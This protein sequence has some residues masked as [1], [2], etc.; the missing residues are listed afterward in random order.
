MR[1]DPHVLSAR[2]DREWRSLSRRPDHIARARAW[3]VTTTPFA[4]LDGLLAL[5]GYRLDH[6][7]ER[8]AVLVALVRRGGHDDLAARIVLQRVMPGLLAVIRRRGWS[9]DGS[10]EELVGAAWL[11]I[12]G[13]RAE[14]APEQIAANIV[15]DAAYRAFTAPRR[16]RSA[17]EVSVDPKTL[18][19]T[20]AVHRV[21]A[22]EELAVLMSDAIAAGLPRHDLE[23]VRD[24]VTIGSPGRVA[25]HRQVTP[26]TIRNHRD[27]ATAR[28][29]R[30]ALDAA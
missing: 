30:L 12:R 1:S 21:S 28:L 10:F 17:T 11:A 15:R 24:L 9:D 13:S 16:R 4:D 5:A 8:N 26:R 20:P 6:S 25:T 7:G 14:R 27:R 2:L 23:L 3:G 19:E 18:D 29:R 22:C